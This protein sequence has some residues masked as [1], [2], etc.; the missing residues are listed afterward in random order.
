MKKLD[1]YIN[2][3]ER[4]IKKA[5]YEAQDANKNAYYGKDSRD[6]S[7]AKDYAYYARKHAK[8]IRYYADKAKDQVDSL[9]RVINN[10]IADEIKEIN[11]LIR[12]LNRLEDE[13]AYE[14]NQYAKNEVLLELKE[15]YA[16]AGTSN[17]DAKKADKLRQKSIKAE[18]SNMPDHKNEIR[19][20][21]Y[22]I[23]SYDFRDTK[24]ELDRAETKGRYCED[25]AYRAEYADDVENA[26]YYCDKAYDYARDAERDLDDANR[27]FK[28]DLY[29]VNKKIG[30]LEEIRNNVEYNINTNERLINNYRKKNQLINIRT[31]LKEE[32][33]KAGTKEYN[34][35]RA[36]ELRNMLNETEKGPRKRK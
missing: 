25:E 1:S 5:I 29:D 7:D 18:C 22:K 12:E 2:D 19:E 27:A 36:A 11:G 15:E 35:K 23:N 30:K 31:M 16:K 6:L 9:E 21:D 24:K 13:L 8:D 26:N 33:A 34:A 32:Y 28:N 10:N 17:Y 14:L 3:V 20:R 4:D